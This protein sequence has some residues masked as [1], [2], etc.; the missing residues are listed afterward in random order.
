MSSNFRLNSQNIKSAFQLL[1]YRQEDEVDISAVLD[2]LQ[3]LGYE[4][5]HPE[6]FDLINSLGEGKINY[7]D[8]HTTLTDMMNQKEEDAGLQRMYDLLIYNPNIDEIDFDTLKKICDE[9]GNPLSDKEIKFALREIGN[10][11]TISIDDFIKFMKE[12]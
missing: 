12:K 8:F 6:L 10:G 5:S 11:K 4:K 9:T 1:D 7:S 3:K 2:N